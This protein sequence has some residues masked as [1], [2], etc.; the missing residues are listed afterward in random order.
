MSRTGKI[1]KLPPSL[2]GE[3]NHQLERGIPGGVLVAWLNAHPTVQAVLSEFFAGAPV[4]EQNLSAWRRGGFADW[5]VRRQFFDQVREVAEDAGEFEK[6]A[7]NMAGHASRL[8]AAHYAIAL[9]VLPAPRA[10]SS[11]AAAASDSDPYASLARLKP[12]SAITRSVV[13]LCRSDHD[14]ARLRMEITALAP[15]HDAAAAPAFTPTPAKPEP[16]RGPKVQ[17]ED[18]RGCSEARTEP[19]VNVRISPEPCRGDRIERPR[20]NVADTFGSNTSSPKTTPPPGAAERENQGK[21]SQIKAAK[22]RVIPLFA[23][24]T[25]SKNSPASPPAR[26]LILTFPPALHFLTAPPAFSR[27]A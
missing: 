1:A 5:Q 4:N 23:S 17:P 9:S 2:Q 25:R 27:V 19:P 24:A 6:V 11:K 8:I 13:A 18:S 20:H 3:L 10:I 22:I 14:A 7:A 16:K 26:H 12:L 15:N 21:S